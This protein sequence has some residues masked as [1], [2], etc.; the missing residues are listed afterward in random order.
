MNNKILDNIHDLLYYQLGGNGTEV[1]GGTEAHVNKTYHH[2]R[3]NA[4]TVFALLQDED[5]LELVVTGTIKAGE[6]IKAREGK[7]IK[8][9]TLSSGSIIGVIK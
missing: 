5:D 6:V 4:D 8:D 3:V 2:I 1:L 7:L 9:I